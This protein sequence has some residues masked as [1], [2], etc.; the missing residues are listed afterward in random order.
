MY[1]L[2]I[3]KYAY[4]RTS[5]VVSPTWNINCFNYKPTFVKIAILLRFRPCFLHSEHQDVPSTSCHRLELLKRYLS[6]F[7]P[8]LTFKNIPVSINRRK[9]SIEIFHQSWGFGICQYLENA[10]ANREI[11]DISGISVEKYH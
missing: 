10:T 9:I 6:L 5:A 11:E 3:V 1:I 2:Y 8:D 7:T 4:I